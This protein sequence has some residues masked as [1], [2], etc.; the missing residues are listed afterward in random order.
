[1]KRGNFMQLVVSMTASSPIRLPVHYGN[2]VQGL[3]YKIMENPALP[4]YLHEQGFKYQKRSFK[5]FTFSR[6]LAKNFHY[7][8]EESI[9]EFSP[10]FQLIICSPINYIL[11]EIGTGLLKNHRLN[12]GGNPLEVKEIKSAAPE[13]KKEKIIVRM[14]SPLVV[15]STYETEKNKKYTYYYSP[16]EERFGELIGANLVKKCLLVHGQSINTD[17]FS[18]HPFDV[19][20]TDFKIT[21]YKGFIIKGWLGK[22]EIKGNTALLQMALDAGLGSKNSQGYGCCELI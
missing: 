11:R 14:L 17:G 19:S 1:M 3:I 5:L 8:K 2:Q 12:L 20:K 21:K 22:Y 4:K 15:Y 13:V 18:I 7:I 16:F 10:P 6:L 9:F